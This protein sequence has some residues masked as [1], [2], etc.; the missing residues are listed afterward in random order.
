MLVNL[1]NFF[2]A[3]VVF[4]VIVVVVI[5]AA[6]VVVVL[7]AVVVVVASAAIVVPGLIER[8]HQIFALTFATPSRKRNLKLPLKL[9][10]K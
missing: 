6:V 2:V 5:L 1:D 4:V 7:A 3:A 10:P 8:C 9:F